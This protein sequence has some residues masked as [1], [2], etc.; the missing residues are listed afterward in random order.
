MFIITQ[1][2]AFF[3]ANRKIRPNFFGWIVLPHKSNYL[4]SLIAACGTTIH[5]GGTRRGNRDFCVGLAFSLQLAVQRLVRVAVEAQIPVKSV[6]EYHDL[7]HEGFNHR[8][9]YILPFIPVGVLFQCVLENGELFRVV[10]HFRRSS[11]PQTVVRGFLPFI[12]P[13]FR[14]LQPVLFCSI[15]RCPLSNSSTVTMGSCLP[16][17]WVNSI[18]P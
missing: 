3:N 18:S 9:W 4:D 5:G 7:H 16:C 2:T 11:L 8:L 12:R 10:H 14:F 15:I 6:L 13:V 17:A 1:I